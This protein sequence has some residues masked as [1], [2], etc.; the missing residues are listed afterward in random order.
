M[1]QALEGW[2]AGGRPSLLLTEDETLIRESLARFFERRGYDVVGAASLAES[3][4]R[5]EEDDFDAVV[6]DVG[7]PDGDGLSL[8]ALVPAERVI[9][10]SANPEPDRY[11]RCAVRHHF[12]K[13]LDLEVLL[14]AVEGLVEDGRSRRA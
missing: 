11:A 8:L 9:V 1:A 2:V 6:L 7:L 5:L 10:I 14:H 4:A 3:Q 12:A 13:P